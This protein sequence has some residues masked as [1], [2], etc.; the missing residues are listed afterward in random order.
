MIYRGSKL[1]V[2]DNSGGY[3]AKCLR[4]INKSKWA[5]LGGL[6]LVTLHKFLW[7]KKVKKKVF[8]L[9]LVVNTRYWVFRHNG[10]Y[11]R[12]NF[13]KILMFSL[14][15]KFLGSRVFGLI[16]MSIK[17]TSLFFKDNKFIYKLL[18]FSC[19]LV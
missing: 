3:I 7:G 5:G 10:F 6:I 4:V 13:N 19:K 1:K 14:Q 17:K 15:L 12:Y 16:D 18:G 9:G 2:S 11:L 8:Y